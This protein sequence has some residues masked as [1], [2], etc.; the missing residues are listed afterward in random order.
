MAT[1]QNTEFD[2]LQR[3]V[4]KKILVTI[5]GLAPSQLLGRFIGP[6]VLLNSIPKAGT[7]LLERALEQL[8]L[9]R[10]AGRRTLIAPDHIDQKTLRKISSTRKGQFLNAH[11]PAYQ[12]LLE[13]INELDIKVLFMIRDPRDVVLSRLKYITNI[14]RTHKKFEHLK[15]IEN[16]DE[17]IK[18]SICGIPGILAPVYEIYERFAPWLSHKNVL[19]CRFEELIGEKG[20]GQK[21]DQEKILNDLIDFLGLT[22]KNHQIQGIAESI[23][24]PKSST[25]NKGAIGG[26][27][28]VFSEEHRQ[29]FM[30]SGKGIMD[31][32]G[33]GANDT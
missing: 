14:D 6:K 15:R 23:F 13:I 10:N 27:K 17:L 18:G 5:H 31:L 7:H 12:P 16:D 9:I 2:K 26:W 21:V 28:N 22:V 30:K 1:I 20:G 32:Y 4:R 25:F 8:P 19:V 33:Y 29:L 11:L 24:S 3:H